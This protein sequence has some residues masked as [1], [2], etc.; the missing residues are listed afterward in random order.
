MQSVKSKKKA[1]VKGSLPT[2]KL[3]KKSGKGITNNNPNYIQTT[4]PKYLDAKAKYAYQRLAKALN[5]SPM[6]QTSAL[7]KELLEVLA[8][9]YS[10]MQE[11]VRTIDE[12][13]Q[14][15][16]TESGQVKVNPSVG[17][18]DKA[19]KNIKTCLDGLGMSPSSRAKILGDLTKDDAE[20]DS[21]QT[22][23]QMLGGGT[24][25]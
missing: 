15:Y 14:T 21:G 10:L 20:D 9:N 12:H 5:S 6:A 23:E 1:D 19:S 2:N 22:L 3:K 18:I 11:A 8:I 16:T 13:G 4:P 25:F 24:D 17:I 7:D